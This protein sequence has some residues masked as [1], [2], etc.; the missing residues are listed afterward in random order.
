M[1]LKNKILGI[2]LI[3][4]LLFTIVGCAKCISTEYEVVEVT[5]TDSYH[6]GPILR[7]VR[8]GKT[9]VI[10]TV[11][12]VYQIMVEY[13]GVTYTFSGQDLYNTYKD[14]IGET[15]EGNLEIKKYD[16]G[17]IKHNIISLQ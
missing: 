5:I 15:T 8:V 14:K 9:T 10:H 13:D 2:G 11:P 6:R 3:L 7:P 4:V 12:A 16:D 1:K 17:A